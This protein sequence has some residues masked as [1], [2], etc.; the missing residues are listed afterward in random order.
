[1]MAEKQDRLLLR[2]DLPLSFQSYY[3]KGQEKQEGGKSKYPLA[4]ADLISLCMNSGSQ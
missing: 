2:A 4:M 3:S 1:M